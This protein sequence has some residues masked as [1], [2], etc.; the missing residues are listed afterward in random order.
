MSQL[1]S[2]FAIARRGRWWVNALLKGPLLVLCFALVASVFLGRVNLIAGVFGVVVALLNFVWLVKCF[3]VSVGFCLRRYSSFIGFALTVSL[4]FSFAAIIDFADAYSFGSIKESIH[5][6][7][8]K[9][10]A[11]KINTLYLIF[12]SIGSIFT[13][14]SFI[15]LVVGY[16]SQQYQAEQAAKDTA[17]QLETMRA[18]MI[19]QQA[20]SKI[21]QAHTEAAL[22]Q[23]EQMR[24]AEHNACQPMLSVSVTP[25][26]RG[27]GVEIKNFGAH[28]GQVWHEVFGSGYSASPAVAVFPTNAKHVFEILC[29]PSRGGCF[30][31]ALY[32]RDRNGVHMEV[33]IIFGVDP[34]FGVVNLDVGIPEKRGTSRISG[35]RE[36]EI[37]RSDVVAT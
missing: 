4:L 1:L 31:L 27:L 12:S 37:V 30:N 24:I 5:L 32:Y 26:V 9:D 15:W 3:N 36:R 35:W 6:L 13:A 2:E 20:L 22:Q 16:F 14:L 33:P 25:V 34:G 8:V 18:S 28:V 7:G 11:A 29:D 21:A 17:A 19:E 23:L 10:E